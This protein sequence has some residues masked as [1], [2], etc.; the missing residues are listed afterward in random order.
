MTKRHGWEHETEPTQHSTDA[1]ERC[2]E[3]VESAMSAANLTRDG[4]DEQY[5]RVLII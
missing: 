4:R 1:M 3:V 5:A 2:V